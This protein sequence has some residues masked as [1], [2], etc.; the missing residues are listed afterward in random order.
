MAVVIAFWPVCDAAQPLYLIGDPVGVCQ[1]S[2]WGDNSIL[3]LFGMG[4]MF[5]AVSLL[6]TAAGGWL[7]N[8]DHRRALAGAGLLV[9]VA[10]SL[11]S[12]RVAGWLGAS[13]CAG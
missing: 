12:S 6:A 8:L 2:R 7:I 5:T 1:R 4:L 10:I 9:V 11:L 3:L 13:G